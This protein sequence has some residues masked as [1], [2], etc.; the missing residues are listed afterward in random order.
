M[1]KSELDILVKNLGISQDQIIREEAEL[2]ILD[3]LARHTLGEKVVFYGGTAL[4]L[5][6][7]SPRFSE[8]IDLLRI[9]Q[10]SFSTF[11]DFAI[12]LE[13]KN[14]NWKLADI[15]EKRH[16]F[17]ALFVIESPFLKHNFSVKI[18]LHIPQKKISLETRLALI[19][20]PVSVLEPLVLVP[21]LEELKRL[22][23][24]ALIQRKKA[25]DLFDLWY[26]AQSLRI[27]FVLPEKLPD[28]SKR[29]F[30]NELKVFLP[31]K[32]YPIIRDIYEHAYQK[33]EK[34]S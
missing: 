14:E 32:Y 12:S 27:P 23:E 30:E 13:K 20:S 18:E 17:F 2:I 1:E 34:H 33:N 24:E 15:K 19:K 26:I 10:C 25:R 7:N 11:E 9:K 6:Y 16:T 5:A 22:K 29:E 4:R 28:F 21:T 3:A 31:K 8:D